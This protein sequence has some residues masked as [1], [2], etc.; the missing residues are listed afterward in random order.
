MSSHG[1]SGP[2]AVR[3]T[4]GTIELN[5]DR[6]PAE[7]LRLVVTNGGDRPVQVG[8]H[9]HLPDANAAL[10]FDRTVAHGCRLDIP[11]GTSERFEPGVSREVALVTLRGS[12]RVPGLQRNKTAD[13]RLDEPEQGR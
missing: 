12:R 5:A 6:A 4:P 11:A 2:G 13:G 3:V 9:I 8:S 1:T 10:R 7:R